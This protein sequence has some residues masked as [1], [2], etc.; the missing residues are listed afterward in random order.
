MTLAEGHERLPEAEALPTPK[1]G[2]RTMFG[3]PDATGRPPSR[4]CG[5]APTSSRIRLWY[6]LGIGEDSLVEMAKIGRPVLI[7]VQ[8]LGDALR[9]RLHQETM[10]AEGFAVTAV[11]QALDA[12]GAAG[13]SVADS[14]DEA[15]EGGRRGS[16]TAPAPSR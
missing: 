16:Q 9:H 5:P 1:P 3:M 11:E 15:L 10:L 13:L 12:T 4:A 7:G 6:S 8:T 14:N 2:P